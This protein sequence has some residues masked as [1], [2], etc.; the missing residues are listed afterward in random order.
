MI[1]V[2]V[3]MVEQM[4]DEPI[5]AVIMWVDGS[6]PIHAEKLHRYLEKL[7]GKRPTA[8]NKTRFHD[9]G[10]LD[11]CDVAAQVCPLAENNF[12]CD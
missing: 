1:E 3:T 12:Y 8:A 4:S 7:G 11:Y 9:A 5:D 10:E 2:I 6:D